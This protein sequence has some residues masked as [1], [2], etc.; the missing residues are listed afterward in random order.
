M[1]T[2]APMPAAA[3]IAYQRIQP[4]NASTPTRRSSEGDAP[5]NSSRR[6]DRVTLSAESIAMWEAAIGASRATPTDEDT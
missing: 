2:I 5:T 1:N 6:S 3:L 4:A